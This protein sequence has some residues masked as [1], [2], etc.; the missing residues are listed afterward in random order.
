MGLDSLAREFSEQ[1]Y[2]LVEG[3]LSPDEVAALR[4]V[5]ERVVQSATGLEAERA[6]SRVR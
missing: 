1:G 4:R 2:C 3:V 5:T 6:P